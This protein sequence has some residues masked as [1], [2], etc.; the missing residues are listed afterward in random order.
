MIFSFNRSSVENSNIISPFSSHIIFFKYTHFKLLNEN[1]ITGSTTNNGLWLYTANQKGRD[2]D[3]KDWERTIS[4]EKQTMIAQS[5][6][7]SDPGNSGPLTG[8]AL[9]K[10]VKTLG[11]ASPQELAKACGYVTKANGSEYIDVE[12]YYAALY[13]AY[14]G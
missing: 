3:Q 14:R 9:I 1:R 7:K 11:N 6:E 12:S 8:Q 4:D 5:L 13:E 2:L 10:K